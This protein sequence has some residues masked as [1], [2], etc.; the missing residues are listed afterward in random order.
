MPTLPWTDWPRTLH[1]APALLGVYV[2]GCVERGDGSSFRA[3]AHAHTAGP[4]AGWICVRAARRLAQDNLMRHELAHVVTPGG[5]TDAWRHT[6]LALGGSLTA[7][8]DQKDYHKRERRLK[9]ARRP[10][11]GYRHHTECPCAAQAG[12]E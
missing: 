5:H 4:W 2:G 1:D 8:R 9:D 12:G 11:L 6:L 7:T 3:Q 10:H